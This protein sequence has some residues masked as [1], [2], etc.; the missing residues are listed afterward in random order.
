METKNRWAIIT[1]DW[2]KA[3]L[4]LGK[5]GAGV[6]SP[7]ATYK[8]TKT[9]IEATFENGIYVRWIDPYS[10]AAMRGYKFHR[11]WIDESLRDTE[12]MR[13]MIMPCMICAQ[14][15]DIQWI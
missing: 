8:T 6:D 14:K 15:E 13:R 10:E 7:V 1:R 2:D 9:R 4:T 3:K 11:A 5:I 12:T